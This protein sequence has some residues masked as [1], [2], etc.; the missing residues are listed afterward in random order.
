MVTTAVIT[1]CGII[2]WHHA[3]MCL[4]T[5]AHILGQQVQNSGGGFGSDGDETLAQGEEEFDG[6]TVADTGVDL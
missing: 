2:M 5:T 6:F 3:H 1:E 4:G